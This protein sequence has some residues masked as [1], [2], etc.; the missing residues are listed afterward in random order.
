MEN[1]GD[2]GTRD[3]VEQ[4]FPCGCK[5]RHYTNLYCLDESYGITYCPLHKAAPKLLWALK[6][7]QHQIEYL[8]S[9]FQVT[10]SGNQTMAIIEQAIAE[11]EGK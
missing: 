7:A 11:A 4:T 9:K 6:V 3:H 1:T 10:A 8:H 2:I 5:I